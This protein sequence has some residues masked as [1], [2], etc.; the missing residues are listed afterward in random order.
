MKKM[1]FRAISALFFAL[2]LALSVRAGAEGQRQQP[3]EYREVAA[4]VQLKDA[5]T[6]L[7]E[8]ER[9]KVAYPKAEMMDVIDLYILASKIELAD[10]L[11]AVLNLQKGLFAKSTG[12]ER[13]QGPYMA[14]E[15]ILRHPRL[16]AFDKAKVTEAVLKYRDQAVKA[17]GDPETLKGMSE[18]QQKSYKAY[19]VTGMEILAAQAH[20]NAGDAGKALAALDSYKAAGGALDAFYSYTLAEAEVKQGKVK[21]AYQA[22]LIAATED[23]EDAKD[24]ARS[25]YTTLNGKPD[26]F[27]A[28]LEAKLKLSPTGPSRSKPLPTGR[29][30]PSWPSSS[31]ALNA[32]PAWAR[33]WDLTA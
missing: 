24:R 13:L 3:P 31:P 8:F 11:D 18:V 23:Y 17:G 29:E 27:E 12:P 33:T 30:R 9:I 32:P 20:L 15:Q 22:Y 14:A 28:Q 4:A 21:D 26:G 10:T 6:R 7:K 5:A 2:I 19:F 1:S 25:L 16:K